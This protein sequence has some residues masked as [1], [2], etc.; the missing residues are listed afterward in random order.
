MKLKYVNLGCNPII[1]KEVATIARLM[2]SA[3]QL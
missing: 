2:S 1:D 3:K